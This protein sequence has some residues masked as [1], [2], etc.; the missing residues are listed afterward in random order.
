[1]TGFAGLLLA[2]LRRA[3]AR[4]W[5]GGIAL[6]QIRSR[7]DAHWRVVIDRQTARRQRSSAAQTGPQN[8]DADALEARDEREW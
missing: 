2:A 7:L 3:G 6:Y 5:N 1:L 4:R 8:A